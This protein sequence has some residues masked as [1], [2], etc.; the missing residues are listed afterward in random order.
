M[1]NDNIKYFFRE[2]LLGK[3]IVIISIG[4]QIFLLLK[5]ASCNN[6]NNDK[7]N[8]YLEMMEEDYEDYQIFLDNEEI[9]DDIDGKTDT[10]HIN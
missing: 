4:Y 5:M 10:E 2:T 8:K 7:I 6:N 3:S 1:D 9:D